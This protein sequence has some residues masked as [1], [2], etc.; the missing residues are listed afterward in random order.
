MGSSV[1]EGVGV[2]GLQEKRHGNLAL[3]LWSADVAG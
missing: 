3:S 1:S 2:E